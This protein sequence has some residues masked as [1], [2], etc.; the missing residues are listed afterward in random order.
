MTKKENDNVD[1]LVLKNFRERLM[2]LRVLETTFPMHGEDGRFL[3]N[4]THYLFTYTP[5][6]LPFAFE[7]YQFSYEQVQE[8]YALA[9]KTL[10]IAEKEI[11]KTK[12]KPRRGNQ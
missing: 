10:E 2:A 8:F 6:K 3:G 11:A 9:M 1:N 5:K 7:E 12:H 4:K